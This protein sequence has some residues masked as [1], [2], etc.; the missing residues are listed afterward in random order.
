MK[1]SNFLCA[2]LWFRY[3]DTPTI[4]KISRVCRCWRDLVK[5]CFVWKQLAR[6]SGINL[7]KICSE[8]STFSSC[9][10]QVEVRKQLRW[11]RNFRN[12]KYRK[13]F[14]PFQKRKNYNEEMERFA[15]CLDFDS[16]RLI[17]GSHEG[18]LMMWKP[19]FDRKHNYCKKYRLSDRRIDFVH[20]YDDHVSI[21]EGGNLNIYLIDD[22]NELILEHSINTGKHII[23]HRDIHI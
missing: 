7:V 4:L 21:I 9:S 8:T 20:I 19:S 18:S 11:R 3:V 15:S 10:C 13:L 1:I 16:R 5:S 22:N 14:V 17:F 12:G 23:E 2:L 6:R